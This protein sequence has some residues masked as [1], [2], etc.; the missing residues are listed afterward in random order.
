MKIANE[1]IWI[2]PSLDRR[3]APRAT[4]VLKAAKLICDGGEFVCS[5]KNVSRWGIKLSHFHPIPVGNTYDLE[6]PD[7]QLFLDLNS[8]WM[9]G[10][11]AGFALSE[12]INVV[13][14]LKGID[15][16]KPRGLQINIDLDIHLFQCDRRSPARLLNLGQNGACVETSEWLAIDQK[17]RLISKPFGEFEAIVRWRKQGQYG[18]AFFNRMTLAELA[19]LAHSMKIAQGP[20]WRAIDA[21]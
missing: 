17:I 9:M 3:S 11:E 2:D 21:F 20:N 1:K 8:I 7:G 15:E 12:Q 19:S 13:K 16:H 18:L 6:L 4:T 14:F 5:V 10:W